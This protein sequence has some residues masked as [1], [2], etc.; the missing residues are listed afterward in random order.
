M[1][2]P[3]ENL[4]LSDSELLELFRQDAPT[5]WQH[6]CE[7]YSDFIYTIL[8]RS[9]FD[10]DEAMERFVY[11]S[12]KLCEQDFRRLKAIKYAG[13]D[14]DLT[15]WLRQ[16]VKNLCVNWAWS[17]DGRKRLFGFVA[18][19]PPRQQ[20]VFQM[21][22][23]QGNTPFEIYE[24][25]RLEHDKTVELGDVFDALEEI[26]LHLSEKKLWRLMSNLNRM[27]KTLSLDYEDEET[28][29][30]LDI[31]D[32]NAPNAETILQKK[33]IFQKLKSAFETL[34]T[35]EKL[36][37]QFRYEN[38][39]TIHEIAEMLGWE[40]R[41]AVNLHKSAIYKLRKFFAIR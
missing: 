10:Y 7:K 5:A 20:R 12:E 34:S 19:M 31:I 28:G 24:N 32:E 3:P 6:F 26:F 41:E 21:Y 13:N 35:R 22:F 33:E 39:M 11:V 15:P 2:N 1:F 25:L 36:V 8:R 18:E 16:V 17:A 14:G 29:L 4:N 9:G 38:T 37:V 23:W 27:R 40:E 30:K